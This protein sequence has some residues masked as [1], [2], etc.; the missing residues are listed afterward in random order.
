MFRISAPIAIGVLA[1]ALALTF[2]VEEQRLT[3]QRARTA[4]AALAVSN[5]EAQRDSTRSLALTNARIAAIAGD[6]LRIVTKRAMQLEQQRDAFDNALGTERRS[7]VALDATIDSLTRVATGTTTVAGDVRV[8]VF[9]VRQA[10]YTVHARVEVPQPPDSATIALRVAL[11]P[12]HV[13]TR[14]ECSSPNQAGVSEA[15]VT[16]QS[17]VQTAIHFDR[18]EQSPAVCQSPPSAKTNTDRRFLRFSP[19]MVGAGRLFASSG[20][21]TWGFFVGSGILIWI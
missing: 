19:L 7:V 13:E 15:S 12:I 14:I 9:D 8:A 3:H 18:V 16:A 21:G 2:S 20:A 11:D 6:S 5:M 17:S 4:V 1:L 10:P